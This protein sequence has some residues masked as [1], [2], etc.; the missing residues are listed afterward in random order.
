MPAVRL[1]VFVKITRMG[2]KIDFSEKL[3]AFALKSRV[4]IRVY[5]DLVIW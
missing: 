5:E 1:L 4:Y 2:A 3:R